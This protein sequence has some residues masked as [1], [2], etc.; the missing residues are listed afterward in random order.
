MLMSSLPASTWS[1]NYAVGEGG[2]SLY[3]SLIISHSICVL[4]SM[5]DVLCGLIGGVNRVDR[6]EGS[7]TETISLASS[8]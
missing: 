8:V 3:K 4:V 6:G 5:S 2:C 7:V 1:T